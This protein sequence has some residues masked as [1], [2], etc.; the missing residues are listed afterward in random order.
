MATERNRQRKSSQA[1]KNEN[2]TAPRGKRSHCWR[3]GLAVM[4]LHRSGSAG[5]FFFLVF[6][7]GH[8]DEQ[9]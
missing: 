1:E 9:F 7:A 2:R 5:L 3:A 4:A 8:G 6:P